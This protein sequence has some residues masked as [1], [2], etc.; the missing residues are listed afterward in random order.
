MRSSAPGISGATDDEAQAVE[1]RLQVVV[2][3]VRRRSQQGRVVRAPLGIGQP[4]SFEVRSERLRPVRRGVRHPVADL[5]DEPIEVG[6]RRRHA[7]RQERRHA[8]AE[9]VPRHPVQR[10]SAAHRVVAPAA[11]DVDVDEARGDVRRAAPSAGSAGSRLDA[12]DQAVL[13]RDRA[14]LDHVVED[15]STGDRRHAGDRSAS[16][17]ASRLDV[18][19]LRRRTARPGRTGQPE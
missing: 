6:Q 8:V 9:Q 16:M 2:A 14:R 17:S 10:G 4:R 15:Q 1:V 19:A 11:V 12:D 3:Q 5:V 7:G 13:D 18:G